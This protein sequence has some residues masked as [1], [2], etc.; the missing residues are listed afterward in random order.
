[1]FSETCCK[2]ANIHLLMCSQNVSE[3]SELIDQQCS[4]IVLMR[5]CLLTY[6]KT[7]GNRLLNY[8]GKKIETIVLHNQNSVF[9]YQYSK[10]EKIVDLKLTKHCPGLFDV[11]TATLWLCKIN[12]SSVC[13]SV[14]KLIVWIQQKWFYNVNKMKLSC[15]EN[16]GLIFD[17]L[18]IILWS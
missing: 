8:F 17:G 12:I 3:Q 16:N 1:M 11:C 4:F 14:G 15:Q 13:C 9:S 5:C 7:W 18:E 2:L 10:W 6:M